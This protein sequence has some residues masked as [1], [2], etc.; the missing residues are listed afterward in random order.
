M[1]RDRSSYLILT[2]KGTG[3]Y[4]IQGVHMKYTQLYCEIAHELKDTEMKTTRSWVGY[5]IKFIIH[6]TWV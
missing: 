6:A 3:N 2:L 5:V 1:L 4:N